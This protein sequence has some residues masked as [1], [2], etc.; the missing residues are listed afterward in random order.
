MLGFPPHNDYSG[1]GVFSHVVNLK[2]P[3]IRPPPE[4]LNG[5]NDIQVYNRMAGEPVLYMEN[6]PSKHI[7]RPIYVPGKEILFY[8]D[9]DVLHSAPDVAYRSSVMRFMN[10]G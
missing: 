8:R 4:N 6:I 5:D 2:Y 3:R 9:V 1:T 7:I 10:I